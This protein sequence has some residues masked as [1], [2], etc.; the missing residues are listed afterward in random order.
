MNLA[1]ATGATFS[2]AH[3]TL[4]AVITAALAFAGAVWRLP[5]RTAA[6]L[7]DVAVVAVLAF[8]SVLLWRWSANMP[9]L[10]A[11][12]LQG[13]S[14]NDW[15]APILTYVL[16]GLYVDVRPPADPHRYGQTRAGL[17]SIPGRQRHHHLMSGLTRPRALIIAC[18]LRAAPRRGRRDGAVSSIA[19]AAIQGDVAGPGAGRSPARGGHGDRRH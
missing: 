12:G 18:A 19:S 16:L 13:F 7:T 2:V 3:I 11:D 15:A 5:R 14:A 1:A 17:R 9:P 6:G 10:N 4:T 8:A